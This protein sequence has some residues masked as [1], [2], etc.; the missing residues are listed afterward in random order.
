MIGQ[1]RFIKRYRQIINV[2]IRYGFNEVLESLKVKRAGFLRRRKTTY[3]A[4]SYKRPVRLR[5]A[6]EEL[7][8]TFIKIGQLLS[9]RIDLLPP[10]YIEELTR[11]QDDVSSFSGEQAIQILEEEM[12]LKV[13]EVFSDFE[14]RPMAAASISQVHRA[15]FISGEKVVVKIKRPDIEAQVFQDMQI[16][17]NSA[18]F[19]DRKT[20]WGRIYRFGELA[21]EIEHIL[22]EELNFKGEAGNAQ[23]LRHNFYDESGVVVPRV[24]MRYTSRNVLVTDYLEG[25]NL[26]NLLE[27][28]SVHQDRKKRMADSLIDVYF[29]QIFIHG[30]FHGDPHP[31]NIIVQDGDRLA[32]VDF[33]T[34]GIIDEV[35]KEQL[36]LLM[37]YL[38]EQKAEEVADLVIEMGFVPQNINRR[39]LVTDLARMQDKY[40]QMPVENIEI[41]D[42]FSEFLNIVGRHHIRMPYEFL[43]LTKTIVTLESIISQLNPDFKIVEGV[44]KYKH[45]FQ[46]S[47]MMRGKRKTKKLFSVY[48]R[49]LQQFPQH[50]ND[51]ARQAASGDLELKL[52]I[53]QAEPMLK[54]IGKMINRLSFS[55][56]LAS[57]IVGLSMIIGREEILF[58]RE[59]PLAEAALIV[60][61]VAGVWWLWTILRSEK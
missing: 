56:V 13:E 37:K 55:V 57:I 10:E 5:L 59:F 50:L 32:L 2:L 38:T 53:I 36:L 61:G 28:R 27:D 42:L 14:K 45:I 20:Q 4:S 33:G 17:K 26:N 40:Y 48:D 25:T 51:A 16:L 31:G 7:G 12:G 54:R 47:Y 39:S 19:V 49:F 43:L 58:I 34:A 41:S 18:Y 35:F 9:T 8:P 22:L 1:L 6:L 23:R 15:T 24:H 46:K 44:N 21:E 60:A 52:D 30:F 29:K 3:R 11:L